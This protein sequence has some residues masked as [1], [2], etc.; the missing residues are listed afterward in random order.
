MFEKCQETKIEWSFS[1]LPY[2]C[3]SCVAIAAP[4]RY[5][6]ARSPARSARGP[7][8]ARG[9]QLAC[10]YVRVHEGDLFARAHQLVLPLVLPRQRHCDPASRAGVHY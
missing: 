8:A 4:R 9:E 7:G 6:A 10:V 3:S 2:T 1:F 5:H